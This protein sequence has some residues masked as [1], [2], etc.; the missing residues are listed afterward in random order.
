MFPGEKVLEIPRAWGIPE[1]FERFG[2]EWAE[3]GENWILLMWGY[4]LLSV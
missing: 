1:V 4:L 2:V 3:S